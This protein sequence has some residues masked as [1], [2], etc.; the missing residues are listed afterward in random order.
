M[1]PTLFSLLTTHLV[2]DLQK[3]C[4]EAVLHLYADDTLVCILGGRKQALAKLKQ[5]REVLYKYSLVSGYKLNMHQC[6]LLPQR[7]SFE[8]TDLNKAGEH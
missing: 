5:V 8:E 4:P 1:S 6:K 3:K 7:W 2:D